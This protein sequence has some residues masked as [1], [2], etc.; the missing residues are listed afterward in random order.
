MRIQPTSK[1]H[2]SY[3]DCGSLVSKEVREL[4]GRRCEICT[5]T[6]LQ[7]DWS[8]R[9]FYLFISIKN[10]K[11][12]RELIQW[13]INLC[14]AHGKKGRICVVDEPYIYNLQAE[15]GVETLT[16]SEQFKIEKI[17]HEVSRKAEKAINGS[18]HS[19]VSFISWQQ[20]S[21]QTPEWMKQEI[22]DAFS[23]NGSF[24]QQILDQVINVK[25]NG[26]S[27]TKLEDYAKFFLCELPVLIN[28]YYSYA[29]GIIDVYPGFMP[30]IFWHMEK[31][32]FEQQLPKT[33]A[34]IRSGKNIVYIDTE[35]SR[36]F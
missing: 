33:T 16:V 34:F 18:R 17:A 28:A 10:R 5:T 3:R 7:K 13:F 22:W 6:T 20:M 31:S 32:T 26:L 4:L 23:H 24:R 8:Q 9:L 29:Q 12:T 2:Q 21:K 30:N 27:E 11:F 35:T 36:S 14:E 15:L 1:K 25:G 19:G